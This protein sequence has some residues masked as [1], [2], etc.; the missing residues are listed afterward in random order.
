MRNRL[1]RLSDRA[2]RT[3][4]SVIIAVSGIAAVGLYWW[5][6]GLGLRVI[7]DAGASVSKCSSVTSLSPLEWITSV[8]LL[9]AAFQAPFCAVIGATDVRTWLIVQIALWGL[10][11][12]FIYRTGALLFGEPAGL[13]A[14]FMTVGL[15]ETFRF[16]IRPQSDLALLFAT[17]LTLWMLARYL[18]E[19]SPLREL[20]VL[21]AFVLMATT[22][23][24]GLPLVAGWTAWLVVR[25]IN[26]A[27]GR[28][29]LSRTEWALVA[30]VALIVLLVVPNFFLERL[31]LA[32]TDPS[33]YWR[34]SLTAAWANGI[35]VT[36]PSTPTFQYLYTPRSASSVAGWLF[37]N[38]DHLLV[39]ALFRS[40]FFFVPVLPRW[41][42]FHIAVNLVTILPLTL[43]TFAGIYLL[44]KKRRADMIG[45]LATPVGM[46]VLTMWAFFLDGGF[47]YRAPA[48][49]V[50]PLICAYLV[51]EIVPVVRIVE[52]VTRVR[53][54]RQ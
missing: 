36:H 13:L 24:L 14:G 35:V 52:R 25:R 47:N 38:V 37:V 41:S 19:Q 2:S 11:C 10:A 21:G 43:G 18:Q 30:V 1:P 6:E 29:Q 31:Q 49:L 34:K 32:H 40:A 45:L 8:R 5:T 50:F 46:S 26:A 12:V 16:A 9:R 39:M 7:G 51:T 33:V 15:W 44:W 28:S 17:A 53:S 3:V 23:P 42:T 4:R 27:G 20:A 54:K 22:R 48:T